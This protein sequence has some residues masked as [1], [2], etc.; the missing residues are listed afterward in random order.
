MNTGSLLGVAMLAAFIT[1]C[2]RQ[3]ANPRGLPSR[4]P[5]PRALEPLPD[6]DGEMEPTAASPAA[7]TPGSAP[8]HLE[9]DPTVRH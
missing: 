7:R 9:G 1:F 2:F 8:P 6:R 4:A 3:P 5:L